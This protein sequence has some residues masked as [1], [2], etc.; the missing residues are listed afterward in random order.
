MENMNSQLLKLSWALKKGYEK[1]LEDILSRFSL[2]QNEGSV[3]LF[4]D[5]QNMTTAKEISTYR[6]ISKSLV[7]KSVE[8]LKERGFLEIKE[9]GDD[10]RI[11]RLYL[12]PSSR[13]VVKDLDLAHKQFYAILEKDLSQNEL[14]IMD[15]VISQVYANIS[16]ELEKLN[17]KG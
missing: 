3:L 13:E 8:S 11:R 10:K 5:H 1:N 2:S 17:E 15:R 9:D 14:K 16:N 12:T 6:S 7:S 4:L